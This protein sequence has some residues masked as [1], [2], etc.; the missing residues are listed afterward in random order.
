MFVLCITGENNVPET[1]RFGWHVQRARYEKIIQFHL[2]PDMKKAFNKFIKEYGCTTVLALLRAVA[3]THWLVFRFRATTRKITREEQDKINN[4]RK[5]VRSS[6]HI[7]PTYATF[8]ETELSWIPLAHKL[9]FGEGHARRAEAVSRQEP[10][11]C[12]KEPNCWAFYRRRIVIH[13]EVE[14]KC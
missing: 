5:S 6:S 10:S 12:E 9:H 1:S 13:Q 8:H 14:E 3:A 2:V 7:C 4:T 11:S